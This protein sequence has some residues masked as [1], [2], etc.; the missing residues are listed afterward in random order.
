MEHG[1]V[2]L[3]AMA[4]Q[5]IKE[6]HPSDYKACLAFIEEII[7]SPKYIGQSPLHPDNFSLVKEVGGIFAMVAIITKTNEYGKYPIMSAY[8]IDPLRDYFILI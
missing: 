4:I 1:E 3:S 7:A 2:H 5:H 6:R 8:I